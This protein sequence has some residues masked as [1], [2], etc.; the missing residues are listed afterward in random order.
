M[1]SFGIRDV[2]CLHEVKAMNTVQNTQVKRSIRVRDF[3]NDF[4][5]GMNDEDL[6][7]KY[8]LTPTGLERFYDMLQERGIIDPQEILARY[9][10]AD[11]A[12]QEMKQDERESAS[13]ICPS[14]LSSHNVMFD[15]CPDCGVSFQDMIS[16]QDSDKQ[17]DMAL[18]SGASYAAGNDGDESADLAEA[19]KTEGQACPIEL[20]EEFESERQFFEDSLDE[21]DEEQFS[22]PG[23]VAFEAADKDVFG[24]MDDMEFGDPDA[25]EFVSRENLEFGDSVEHQSLDVDTW[26]EEPAQVDLKEEKT[27]FSDSPDDIGPIGLANLSENRA[28]RA[29]QGPIRDSM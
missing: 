28:K 3:L 1:T 18:D 20:P 14:C 11:D 5:G 13:F 12:D 17:S 24:S 25:E 21:D 26:D 9:V 23:E 29:S 16:Q 2:H 19:V 10:E 4:H 22:W 7:V 27:D 6:L 8:H 15:I